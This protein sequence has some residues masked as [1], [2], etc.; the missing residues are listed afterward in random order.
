MFYDPNPGAVVD[1]RELLPGDAPVYPPVKA[2]EYILGRNQGA[3][4]HYQ[5]DET[6]R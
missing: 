5:S 6:N 4:T 2:A 1:P 3:F